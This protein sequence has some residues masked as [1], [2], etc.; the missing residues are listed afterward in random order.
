M[1][2][3]PLESSALDHVA[4]TR[5]PRRAAADVLG[6]GL[7]LAVLVAL[8]TAPSDLDRHQLPKE[9]VMHLATWL[10][11]VLARPAFLRGVSR[12]TMVGLAAFVALSILSALFATNPWI[13][14]R[15]AALTCSGVAAF[16]TARALAAEGFG[17]R[18]LRWCA[19]AAGV[20]VATALAQAYGAQSVLFAATRAPGGTFGNRNF[21]AHFSALA[22]P[23][24]VTLALTTRRTAL[25]T[26]AALVVGGLV[27]GIVLSRSRT[28]WIGA[29]VGSAAYVVA[30]R[31]ASRRHA[32]P[33]ERRRAVLLV[34]AVLLGIA[35][36]LFAPNALEWRSD[37]PF[38]ETLAG[39][40]NHSDGSGRGRLIQY[41]NTVRLALQHPLLGVGP[42]NWPIRYGDVAP[43]N[44]PSWAYNDPVPLNP[45]PSSDW[46]ALLSERGLA[47]IL[48][49]LLV[50]AS[51]LWRGGRALKE[52]GS[53]AMAA[54]TL[55]A[56]LCVTA[57]QGGF[58]AVL[59]LPTPLLLVAIAA[60]ALL[61]MSE[62]VPPAPATDTPTATSRW[63]VLVAAVL[64]VLVVRSGLQTGA[65]IIAG[66]G[67]SISRLNW[68][69]RVDPTSY[70]I[71]IAL[72][73][74]APCSSARDDARAA[75]RLAPE[76][77]APRLAV[78]RC[79][80]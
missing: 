31:F 23:L 33:V 46:M 80:G 77:P 67:R 43:P 59:L 15:A 54:A 17:E 7:V 11:V 12:A 56:V 60:G 24:L 58:D 36:A 41:R 53:P 37:S 66:N 34:G 25:A 10:A 50:G 61:A 42:G 30:L 74:R 5:W 2:T 40:T 72:A 21:M 38:V 28:A 44:D 55:A 48:A 57:A 49:I 71:R 47:A 73:M 62:G 27:V 51:A 4:A 1:M 52:G 6:I 20:G 26:V 65:Y 63:T 35:T 8:P 19:V 18:L 64:S 13:A 9:T 14:W 78:R 69:A 70:P 29:A 32:L 22:L 39:I 76:W 79:G 75:L 3:S 68:A 16:A 45:W